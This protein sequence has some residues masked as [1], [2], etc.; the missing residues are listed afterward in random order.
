LGNDPDQTIQPRRQGRPKTKPETIKPRK[1]VNNVR[2]K[3]LLS[4]A[5]QYNIKGYTKWNKQQLLSVLSKVKKL[6]FKKHDL[7]QLNKNQLKNVAKENNIKVTLKKRKDEIIDAILKTQDSVFREI[8]VSELSFHDDVIEP[9]KEKC[10]PTHT[11]TE[12][13]SLFIKKFNATEVDF[14]IKIN[15]IMEIENAINAII[16]HA[17]K[18]GNYKK[19]NKIT[20]AVSNP[21]FH[22][23]ISVV[24]QSYVKA[25]EFMKHIA[26]IL[27]SNEDLDITQCRFN[28]KTFSIPRGSKPNKII[29]LVN[30]IRTKRCITQIK[31]NDNLCCPRAIITALTYHTNDIFGTKRNITNIRKGLK[32]QTELAGELCERLGGYNE[33][34]FT[35]EDIK[36]LRKY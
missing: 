12:T 36:K 25:N 1:R 8:A 5:K 16:A 13:K 6:F 30:D 23:A 4:Q 9:T 14:T 32:V 26:K 34:G 31:N 15:K 10:K 17:K 22:H 7:Q 21:N 11:I 27:S 24:V 18:E 3:E 28:V 20:I 35:L 2:R 29:N 33:E 19:G